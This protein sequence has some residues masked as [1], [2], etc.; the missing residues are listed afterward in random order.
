MTAN[1]T[2]IF[3]TLPVAASIGT[4][5]TVK[6]GTYLFDTTSGVNPQ[7]ATV[8][9]TGDMFLANSF[10]ARLSAN[11]SAVPEPRQ[12]VGLTGA[13]LVAVG[14]WRR[15]GRRAACGPAS[16]GSRGVV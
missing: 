2:Y 13:G 3:W 1:D 14:V 11:V 5:M 12:T 9:F 4:V 16:R 8:S 6:S 7:L 15:C 10:A